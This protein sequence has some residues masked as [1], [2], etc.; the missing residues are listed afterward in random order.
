MG[1]AKH[2]C[3]R[4]IKTIVTIS[5]TTPPPGIAMTSRPPLHHPLRRPTTNKVKLLHHRHHCPICG[6]L[7]PLQDNCLG[8]LDLGDV[9]YPRLVRL[10]YTNL[11]TKSTPKGVFFVRNV[12]TVTITLSRSVLRYIFGLKFI[13]TAPSILTCKCAK[14]LCLAQFACPHKLAD[15]KHQNKTAPYHV[16]FPEPR[17]LHYVCVRVF[18][19]KGHSKEVS[20][21]IALE[22][23]YYLMTGYS[24][25]Y[26]SIIL[27]HMYQVASLVPIT[28]AHSL[29]TLYCYKTKDGGWQHASDL[30]PEEATVLKVSL[31]NTPSTPN[32]VVVLASLKEDNA[33]L[34]TQLDQ[35]QLDMA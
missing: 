27:D 26:V 34:R 8:L 25:D 21:E 20:N 31:S 28:S 32:V 12:K 33:A 14:V 29:K 5:N 16:L 24:V 30:T 7:T 6:C 13:N 19:P 18:Y 35:I 17:L 10:F 11:E 9:V 15:Y 1:Q 22:A 4:R 23:I 2:P 3:N